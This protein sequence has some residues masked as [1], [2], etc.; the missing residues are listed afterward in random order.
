MPL[1]ISAGADA[2]A[3]L[4]IQFITAEIMPLVDGKFSIEMRA[5]FL[6]ESELEFVGQDL[7]NERVETL[8]QALSVIR[9]NVAVALT[10]A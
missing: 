3:P 6:D 2:P 1:D 7:A 10:A 4:P 5:T 9:Q 8:D